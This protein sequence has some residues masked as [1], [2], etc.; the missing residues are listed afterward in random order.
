MRKVK[1]ISRDFLHEGEQYNAGGVVEME[2]AAAVFAINSGAA[3]Y[4]D[5]PVSPPPS[6][7]IDAATVAKQK[8]RL[9][10]MKPSDRRKEEERLKAL[11]LAQKE[12]DEDAKWQREQDDKAAKASRDQDEANKKAAA[13]AVAAQHAPQHQTKEAPAHR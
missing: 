7:N 11:A 5:E 2:D 9:E 13:A 6:G 4:T 1:I 10:A 12:A 3:I 8:A